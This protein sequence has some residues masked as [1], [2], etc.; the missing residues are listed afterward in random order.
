[1]FH[2]H[3]KFIFHT[4]LL[5]FKNIYS[6]ISD[7]FS[8]FFLSKLDSDDQ[9]ERRPNFMKKNVNK[10]PRFNSRPQEDSDEGEQEQ[11]PWGIDVDKVD[12]DSE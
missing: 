12:S 11:T 8:F 1:M 7:P 3:F 5:Y 10:G 2:F 9:Q 6:Q 4:L